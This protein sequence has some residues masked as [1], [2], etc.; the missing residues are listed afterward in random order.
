MPAFGLS[1]KV[2]AELQ[3]LLARFP[4]VQSAVIYGSRAKGSYR[5]GSDID[6]CLHGQEID[7]TILN[8]IQSESYWLTIPYRIDFVVWSQLTADFQNEITQTGQLFYQK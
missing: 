6:L 4:E 8:Q 7:Q 2:I 1:D 5:D 3:A